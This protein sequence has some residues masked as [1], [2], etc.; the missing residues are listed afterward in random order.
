MSLIISNFIHF[1]YFLNIFQISFDEYI[2]HLEPGEKLCL[3]SEKESRDES[4]W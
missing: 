2:L 1:L 4:S 3:Q